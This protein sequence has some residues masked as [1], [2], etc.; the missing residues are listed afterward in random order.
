[1]NAAGVSAAQ[2][3]ISVAG[4]VLAVLAAWLAVSPFI[5]A[6]SDLRGDIQAERDRYDVLGAKLR[7]PQALSRRLERLKEAANAKPL[8]LVAPSEPAAAIALEAVLRGLIG[9]A[10]TETSSVRILG[11]ADEGGYRVVRAELS[12]RLPGAM[13][14]QLV[15]SI[16]GQLPPVFI[17]KL[18]LSSDRNHGATKADVEIA[19]TVRAFVTVSPTVKGRP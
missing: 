17:E 8:A 15:A 14:T 12:A 4:L 10:G 1:M 5:N 3:T 18:R 2:K 13:A 6:M 19:A 7:D 11:G 16:E 9:R